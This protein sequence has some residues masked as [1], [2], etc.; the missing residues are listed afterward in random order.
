MKTIVLAEKPS[1]GRDLAR[2]LKCNKKTKCYIE[3]NDYIITWAMGHLVEL[4]DP[5]AYEEA[6]KKWDLKIL[7]MLPEKMKHRI[8]KKTSG[9]F[10]AIKSLC[11]RKDVD[12]LIVATDAGREGELVARWIMRLAGWKKPFF[13]LWISSQT[14]SAIK[15]GFKNLKPG[16][17]YDNLLRAAECRAEADWV[18]G[19]NVT[20]ALSCKFDARLSAGRV[21]TPTLGM[22][23]AREKEIEDFTPEPFW[24]IKANFG[25][26]D[27]VWRGKKG[28]DRIKDPAFAEEIVNK[29]RD[30]QAKVVKA[31]KKRKTEAP[32]LAYD[33][34]ELQKDADS[35]LGFS[36]KQTLKTLQ[37]LYERHKIVTYPRTDSK[38]ITPDIVPTLKDRLKAIQTTGFGPFVTPLIQKD[39]KPGKRFVDASKVSDHHALLPTEE[40]VDLSRL[41]HEEKSLW[42]LI[43]RRFI[44]VLSDPCVYE[45]TSAELE[46]EGEHFF[47]KGRKVLDDG[48][49]TVARVA[50]GGEAAQ[51]LSGL[52]SGQELPVKSVNLVKGLTSA[53]SRFTEGTLLAAMENPLKYMEDKSLKDSISGGLGTPATRAD[54]IEK[55]LSSYYV[56]K[57][58]K[59]LVPTPQGKELM[60]LVPPV[61]KQ[62]ELTAQWEKSLSDIAEGKEKHGK[63]LKEVRERTKELVNSVKDSKEVYSPSGLSKKVC[64]MC[65]KH[66]M[67]IHDK[68]G[69]EKFVC[70]SMAC[71]YIEE[72]EADPVYGGKPDRRE[73]AM[74]RKLINQY[75]DK[76]SDTMSLGDMLKAAME[77]KK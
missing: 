59:T 38:Y 14:D 41:N 29:I 68:K 15:E 7:P 28:L 20:R 77:N 50:G 6:W 72:P 36:A 21:Q 61:F 22:I 12:K 45:E 42:E 13:R 44:A 67:A 37:S 8:I 39:L 32:P 11:H 54:I 55:L 74:N 18:V 16:R 49:K 4:A 24:S 17:D 23:V 48:W 60:S 52:E 25:T 63:F 19:L 26:F 51:N 46:A 75:S 69:R 33:L 31:D 76:S 5:S 35:A 10:R 43:M 57:E 66:L 70:R 47:V 73:R 58:G 2:V 34:T 9:Q 3:G 62:P 53:P 56:E 65:G 64:P 1:V 71:G 30:K 40:K 27:A